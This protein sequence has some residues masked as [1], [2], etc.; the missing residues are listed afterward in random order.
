MQAMTG[1]GG[2]PMSVFLTPDL[3]PVLRRHLLPARRLAAGMPGFPRCC[4][5]RRRRLGAASAGRS[6]AR[7]RDPIR[8]AA[9][10][11]DRSASRRA[12][13][14]AQRC[15]PNAVSALAGR[16]RS[17]ATA[18]SATRP[19]SPIRWTSELLL[20]APRAAAGDSRPGT[21]SRHTLHKMA[22]RHLR[23]PRRRL[24]PLLDD[25]RWLVPHFEKM[26]YDNALLTSPTSKPTRPPATPATG[27]VAEETL[28]Y[29]LARMTGPEGGFYSTE[30]A[31]SEGEEVSSGSPPEDSTSGREAEMHSGPSAGRDVRYVARRPRPATGKAHNILNLPR[32]IAQA[33][34]LLGRDEAELSA[35]AR[36][37]PRRPA[38]G[39]RPPNPAGQ[40]YEGPGLVERPDDRG[41]RRGRPGAQ[42]RGYLDAAARAAG[43][44]LDRMRADDGRLLHTYKDG[45]A[46]A[47]TPTSTTTP[48]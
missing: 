34:K 43:F 21:S 12:A 28:D 39:P 4:W 46:T 48:A 5:K 45:R 29:V 30:D 22:R 35:E 38:R 31:D 20:R 3:K 19:S 15:W 27:Q 36:R 11:D 6:G 14:D 32:T 7:R 16:L 26:L 18:A 10:G 8:S 42:G 24:R 23:P 17:Q 1:Q 9:V 2:W 33:A 13:L 40:G 44:I 47:S 37:R 41:P 25:D